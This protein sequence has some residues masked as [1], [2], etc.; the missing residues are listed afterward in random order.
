MEGWWWT[1]DGH[2]DGRYVRGTT[3]EYASRYVC[4]YMPKDQKDGSGS[5]HHRRWAGPVRW[6]GTTAGAGPAWSDTR[7]F[8]RETAVGAWGECKVQITEGI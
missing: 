5:S 2:L 1:L 7:G 6:A 3:T 8:Q 4:T